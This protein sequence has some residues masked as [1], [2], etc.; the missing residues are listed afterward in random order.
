M[1]ETPT[2]CCREFSWDDFWES[3]HH[4]HTCYPEDHKFLIPL[5][6]KA[7]CCASLF[8]DCI[9]NRWHMEDLED[10]V[11]VEG[12]QAS[13]SNYNFSTCRKTVN[14][15]DI[16]DIIDELIKKMRQRRSPA[17]LAHDLFSE[18]RQAHA[19][20]LADDL[21]HQTAS[22]NLSKDPMPTVEKLPVNV[23]EEAK[24]LADTLFV[25]E[26]HTD[27]TPTIETLR[28]NVSEEATQSLFTEEL[29][30]DPTPTVETLPDILFTG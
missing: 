11:R 2:C 18:S 7:Y 5:D 25:E 4:R 8:T 23:S 12:H 29:H 15:P 17:E 14:R 20:H 19:K 1:Y 16:D 9:E 21:F 28:V 3:D 6:G 22:S 27:S 10:I 26:L 24:Q 13:A 30:K